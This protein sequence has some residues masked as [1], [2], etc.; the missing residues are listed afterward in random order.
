MNNYGCPAIL[1]L[2]GKRPKA[3][4]LCRWANRTSGEVASNFGGLR[5][6]RRRISTF[7]TTYPAH[8]VHR[9]IDK[10]P[11]SSARTEGRWKP[12]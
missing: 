5:S 2:L 12:A 3:Q 9:V 7:P 8:C 6:A 4:L 11:S 1:R 10:Q